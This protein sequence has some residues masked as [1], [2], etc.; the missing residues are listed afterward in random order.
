MPNLTLTQRLFLV[1]AVAIMPTVA[2]LAF[3]L[4]TLRHDAEQRLGEDAVATAQIATLEMRRIV[5]GVESTL[6]AIA[7]APVVRDADAEGCGDYLARVTA[8]LP[9]MASIAVADATGQVRCLSSSARPMPSIADRDYFR[10]VRAK[11]VPAVGTYVIGRVSGVA[12]LPIA[13]P[14]DPDTK[15][16]GGVILAELDL[17][18]LGQRIKERS[19][20]SGNALTI[21]DRNGRI[22]AREPLPETFVG[23]TI[24]AAYLHLV[25]APAPGTEIVVSQDGTRRMI[26]YFPASAA[27]DFL[28]ISAGLATGRI[29]AATTRLTLIGAAVGLVGILSA[30]ALAHV[31]SDY[32]VRR[33]FRQLIATIEAWQRDETDRR[34]HMGTDMAEFGSAGRALDGFM[35]Q[36]VAARQA[37]R[38][39][40]RQRELLVKELDHRVKNIVATVQAIARQTFRGKGQDQAVRAFTD[41]LDSMGAAHK[42]L[43]DD[44]W[45]A[46]PI[47]MLVAAAIKPFDDKPFVDSAGDAGAG[48]DPDARRFVV[49]GP[50]IEV[51]AKAAMTLSMALH[52]LCTNAAKYGALSV[53]GGRV[54]IA[55]QV[56]SDGTERTFHL[57][58]TERGG[59]TVE[60]PGERGFGSVMIEQVLA[61]QIGG[62]VTMDFR[63][64]GLVCH[65]RAP[66][67]NVGTAPAGPDPDRPMPAARPTAAAS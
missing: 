46:A 34:T 42:L 3:N 50:D 26:G 65:I 2:I 59:P 57:T 21:A 60:K 44:V 49:A 64:A 8:A 28:Y 27:T 6:Q 66:L 13:M 1:T 61:Q 23:T 53:P 20:A 47:R 48:E 35:D 58:W 51:G 4:V 18:W 25:S 43:L 12:A 15:W 41:R 54:D 19:M 10:K 9:R 29:H 17:A 31:T 16:A 56:G 33:P 11:S 67:H 30:F 52:E 45:Q 55:W 36:L 39:A 14:L 7:N 32:F 37:R 5:S 40:E 22:I 63:P 38:D 24:P 62:E